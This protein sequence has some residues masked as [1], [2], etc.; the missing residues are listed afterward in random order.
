MCKCVC[1]YFHNTTLHECNIEARN[2]HNDK[3]KVYMF[4]KRKETERESGNRVQ[5]EQTEICLYGEKVLVK[6]ASF[7]E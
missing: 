1:L 7:S 2:V 3:K 6:Y 5:N 4:A